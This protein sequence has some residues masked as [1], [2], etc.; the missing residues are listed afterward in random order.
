FFRIR[1][2]SA[3][4][5]GADGVPSLQALLEKREELSGVNIDQYPSDKIIKDTYQIPKE[6]RA[7]FLITAPLASYFRHHD[8]EK[9]D[10]EGAF[11]LSDYIRALLRWMVAV[12]LLSRHSGDNEGFKTGE[13]MAHI[14]NCLVATSMTAYSGKMAG[15]PA[16]AVYHRHVV[17]KLGEELRRGTEAKNVAAKLV[18]F[19]ENL[20]IKTANQ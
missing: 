4:A 9:I 5:D 14:G 16:A 12:S 13:L 8:D 1:V 19:D 15:P 10:P 17:H 11:L 20:G 6:G 18:D 2:M 7:A 3:E